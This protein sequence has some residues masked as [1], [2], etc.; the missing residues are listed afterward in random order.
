MHALGVRSCVFTDISRDGML[1]GPNL[2]STCTFAE[3]T[4]LST[5]VSGG[6]SSLADLQAIA[7]RAHPG[8]EGVIVG[9]AL[10]DG[11]F[12]ADEAARVL[13]GEAS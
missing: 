5:I 12:A 7:D 4:G 10:F 3:A 11:R 6:I 9:K 2:P 1:Q 8:I 13:H